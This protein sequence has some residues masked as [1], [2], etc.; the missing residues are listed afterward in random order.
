VAAFSVNSNVT[1]GVST[2]A[3]IFLSPINMIFGCRLAIR[4]KETLSAFFPSKIAN[5]KLQITFYD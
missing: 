2:A 3:A 1:V 4:L 5:L